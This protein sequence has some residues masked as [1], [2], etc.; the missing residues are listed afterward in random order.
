MLLST[1]VLGLDAYGIRYV[2]R[3]VLVYSLVVALC[4]T[5]VCIYLLVSR[6]ILPKFYDIYVALGLHLWMLIF[7]SV[8]LGLIAYLVRQ[9]EQPRCI[10]RSGTGVQC[11]S[12]GRRDPTAFIKRDDASY[13]LHSGFLIAGAV[14]AALEVILWTVS[15]SLVVLNVAKQHSTV[16]REDAWPQPQAYEH[17]LP[18]TIQLGSA[19][20]HHEQWDTTSGATTPRSTAQPILPSPGEP[21]DSPQTASSHYSLT[22]GSRHSNMPDEVPHYTSELEKWQASADSK[23]YSEVTANHHGPESE[24]AANLPSFVPRRLQSLNELYVLNNSQSSQ[25]IV[26]RPDPDDGFCDVPVSP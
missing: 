20:G 5:M 3:N 25:S 9:W 6:S 7:W 2:V 22:P 8:D 12:Y 18:E 14:L 13:D 10:Y 4:T 23:L 11:T 16:V 15:A 24:S 21:T 17:H 1:A 19:Q 26:Y